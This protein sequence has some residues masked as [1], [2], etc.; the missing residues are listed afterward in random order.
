MTDEPRVDAKGNPIEVVVTRASRFSKEFIATVIALVSTAFGVVVALAWNTAI[1]K[2]FERI[3]NTGDQVP[4][5]FIYAAVVTLIGV[6]VI[7]YLG[8]LAARIGAE[9]VEFKFP[10]TPKS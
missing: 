3:F 1:Q 4:A 2:W 8:R 9:P 10:G 5:L 7:V 6:L